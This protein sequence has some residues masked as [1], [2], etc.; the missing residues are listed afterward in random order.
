MSNRGAR[1]R[2]PH[3][4]AEGQVHAGP[5]R[6]AVDRRQRRQ[7]AAGDAQEALV[8]VAPGS[9]G[10]PICRLP[11][12]APAQNAEP[13][14]VT[15]TAPTASSASNASIAATIAATIGAVSVLRS[16]GI[17]ERQPADAVADV[18]EHERFRHQAFMILAGRR[19]VARASRARTCDRAGR[20]HGKDL[21][22]L[23][24]RDE[25][26]RLAWSAF[27]VNV[28]NSTSGSREGGDMI[29]S[30][31][32]LAAGVVAAL[33]L[34]ACGDDD[35][36]D[37]PTAPTRQPHRRTAATE[38]PAAHR[39]TGRHRGTDGRG[40]PA[41]GSDVTVGLTFD[42][43]GRGDQSFNDSAAA[44]MDRAKADFGVTVN[45]LTPTDASAPRHRPAA[46]GR[47]RRPRDRR[48]LLVRHRR[49]DDRRREPRR[50]LR[51][52]RRRDD[53]LRRSTH[54][55]AAPQR[56]R[57]RVQ[58]GAGLVPRRRRRR[59]QVDDRQ[60]RLHRWRQRHRPDREV[61]GRLHRRCQVDQPR[62][63]GARRSTSPSSPTSPASRAPTV[64][65]RSPRRCTPRAPTSSTPPPACP[66]RAC[67]RP[68]PR[69][70]RPPAP[71]CGASA[72]TP[73][74]TTRSTRRCRS[75]S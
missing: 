15:T 61:R 42:L 10:S 13:A 62:H 50:E 9:R 59:A 68:R 31:R 48:R 38:A 33:A 75:T 72:S 53:E 71:R 73:T 3:V 47:E 69:R 58:R 22:P 34:A 63:R 20:Q 49:G 19:R 41:D 66:A 11:R 44:G 60:D 27:I 14:P 2:Q 65:R 67:S 51:D 52:R 55:G 40:E 64:P 35:D 56:G 4:A 1:R 26:H 8:D 5:D 23:C 12:S 21:G 25:A 54:A 37:A 45:E 16:L 18:G 30:K 24:P 32:M 43:L 74:S 29:K 57:P 17:V 39:G 28:N 36:D 70:P 6:G 7:R 46:A